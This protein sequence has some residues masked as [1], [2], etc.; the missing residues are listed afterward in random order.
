MNMNNNFKKICSFYV[1]DWHLSVML[2]PYIKEEIKKPKSV[3]TFLEKSLK[4]SINVLTSK[5]NIEESDNKIENIDWNS[6]LL[7]K[8]TDIENELSKNKEDKIVIVSGKRDYIEG[9]NKSIERFASN[10]KKQNIKIINCYE[11]GM[12]NEDIREVLDEHDMIL[13]TSGEQEISDVFNGYKK[14]V[15]NE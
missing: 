10:N 13:N 2:L 3:V 7:F 4:P 11:V 8:Y 14:K 5:F 9:V 15:G 6:K 12:F 1:S